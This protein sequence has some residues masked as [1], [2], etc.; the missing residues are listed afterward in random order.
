MRLYVDGALAGEQAG[1]GTIQT[2]DAS[3]AIG[4][5]LNGAGGF[6]G[7]IDEV[8][9]SAVARSADWLEAQYQNQ[10]SPAAAIRAGKE[11]S[12]GR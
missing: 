3:V 9:V 10:K 2:S 12:T 7:R 11:E 5:I 4:R 8:R 1:S 6:A